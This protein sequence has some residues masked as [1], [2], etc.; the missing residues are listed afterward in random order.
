MKNTILFNLKKE[1]MLDI[2]ELSEEVQKSYLE[3]SES[4]LGSAKLLFEHDKLEETISFAYYIA[5]NSI[6]ALFFRVGIKSENHS[7]SIFL[8][9][10]IFDLDN[11]FIIYSKKERINAQYY[12][13]FDL[14]K[15]DVKDLIFETERFNS[16]L[17]DFLSRLTNS[18]IIF[19]RNKFINLLNFNK[20]W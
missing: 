2:I 8:L 20:R 10:K 18:R 9:K 19:Y 1:G 14:K 12:I 15:Q 17:Q 7:A 4:N 13:D 11:K 3:K 16:Y 5:Y 6:L